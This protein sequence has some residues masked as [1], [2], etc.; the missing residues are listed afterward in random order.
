MSY[1]DAFFDRKNN[2]VRVAE[3]SPEGE[4]IFRD[5][6]AEYTLYYSDPRGEYVSMFGDKLSC[7][8][9][10]DPKK[11]EAEK[12][13]LSN[14][15][16]FESDISPLN[17]CLEHHYSNSEATTLN[18]GFLDIEADFDK[19]KG[20]A[21]PND[22]F[23][24]ITALGLHLSWTQQTICLALKPEGMSSDAAQRIGNKNPNVII[25]TDERDML[26]D[27]LEL[28]ED[29]DVFTGWNSEFYDMPYMINRI[30]LLLG[31]D[32]TKRFCHWNQKP[33]KRKVSRFGKDEEVFELIGKVHLDY[34]DLYKKHS[35]QELHSYKLDNVGAAEVGE[36]KVPYEGT[37]DQLYNQDFERFIEYNIQDVDL[38][39]K[40]DAKN[41]YIDLANQVAHTNTVQMKATMGTVGLVE[42]AII[43][44]AHELGVIV[45]DKKQHNKDLPVAGAYVANPKIGLHD[46]VGSVDINSL[47]PS[48]IRSVNMGPE[49]IYGQIKLD[50]T[51]QLIEE[52]MASGVSGSDAWHDMFGTLEF[53]HVEDRTDDIMQIDLESGEK[54]QATGR[55]IAEMLEAND[56]SI[57]ANG[58]L[59]T[60]D[61]DGIIPKIL[62]K[63]YSERSV[64]KKAASD[65]YS[66]MADGVEIDEELAEL[67][68][69]K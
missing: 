67:L 20:Y 69:E 31:A 64:M 60:T 63:W 68:G 8:I 23:A 46:F 12:N 9:T 52:R 24:K 10:H 4:R 28:I 17:R 16:I 14:K 58:T 7:F 13:L 59:F 2:A 19:E 6:P 48:V 34:L 21:P 3:R 42:Q 50:E 61:E 65:Y 27:F 47:Y 44:Y 57:S 1:V 37:L 39:V 49:T 56:L 11:F 26:K 43:N 66:I 15:K 41:R 35:M 25:Y 36:N 30:S 53:N 32:Y 29:V 33:N 22:P 5:Y 40:I 18:I 38:L 55:E 62:E 45:P 51:T 54:I